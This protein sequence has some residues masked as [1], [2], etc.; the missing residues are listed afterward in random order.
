MGALRQPSL[1]PS[2]LRQH[3]FTEAR[4]VRTPTL[5]SQR[6]RTIRQLSPQALFLD[7]LRAHPSPEDSGSHLALVQLHPHLLHQALKV[8]GHWTAGPAGQEKLRPCLHHSKTRSFDLFLGVPGSSVRHPFVA[9]GVSSSASK[10]LTF[11]IEKTKEAR[12]DARN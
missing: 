11:A 7:Y 6:K 5:G 2:S 8:C 9:P 3:K 4:A 1:S 12:W 10:A